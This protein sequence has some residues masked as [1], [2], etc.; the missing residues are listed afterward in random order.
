MAEGNGNGANGNGSLT[1]KFTAWLFQQGTST[2]LLVAFVYCVIAWGPDMLAK[3][4]AGY[5]RNA[6]QHQDAIDK[7]VAESKDARKAADD[8]RREQIKMLRE[9]MQGQQGK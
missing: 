9:V 4:Q 1:S 2:V 7:V 6:K 3:I 5:D 8:D